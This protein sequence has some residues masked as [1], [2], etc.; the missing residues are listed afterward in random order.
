M[1]LLLT[2]YGL[3]TEN[4]QKTF[5]SLLKKPIEETKIIITYINLR[6]TPRFTELMNMVVNTFLQLGAKQEN[7]EKHD[8][9]NETP[10]NI[11]DNL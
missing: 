4:L 2:S 8:L 6:K 5:L 11:K 3:S 10:P 7:I 9:Y 1:N